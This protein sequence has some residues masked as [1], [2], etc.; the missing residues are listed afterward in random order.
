MLVMGVEGERISTL[1]LSLEGCE[2]C[3]S[4]SCGLL[5]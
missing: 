2:E 5:L 4:S 1:L 3:H